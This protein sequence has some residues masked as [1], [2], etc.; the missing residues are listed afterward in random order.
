[1][2]EYCWFS[3]KEC[4]QE[5]HAAESTEL[6]QY[7]VRAK[8]A[9]PNAQ[10][11]DPVCFLALDGQKVVGR[12]QY[13]YGYISDF[14]KRIRIAVAQDLFTD[15]Q[16]RGQGIGSKLISKC[17]EI[18]ISW[19]GSGMSGQALP[20]FERLGFRF[21]D[22]S[23]IYQLPIGV[24][25]I[26]KDW[27]ARVYSRQREEGK[28]L[29]ALA[30]LRETLSSRKASLSSSTEWTAI[31]GVKAYEMLADITKNHYRRFQIPW[32]D[33]LLH[34]ALHEQNPIFR[35]AVFERVEGTQTDRHLVTVYGKMT[36]VRLPLTSGTVEFSNGHLNEI[37][38]PPRDRDSALT[39]LSAI[40]SRAKGWS[41][42]SLAVYAMT[43]SLK[44]ACELLCLTT[45]HRKSVMFQPVGLSGEIAREVTKSANWWCRAM[46]E[47]EIEEAG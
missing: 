14:G 41:F 6:Q 9:S 35:A 20:L 1:M 47:D 43:D 27:R 10:P 32:N 40:A 45:H 12:I 21:V 16:Y 23:P 42:K 19:I 17:S 29:S 5:A 26:I 39:L 7:L 37:F 25:G 28:S 33:D 18:G 2:V 44:E 36:E 24:T 31:S 22:R 15:P 11:D 4:N 38:P 3:A 8:R 46:N 30:A 34:S 13:T